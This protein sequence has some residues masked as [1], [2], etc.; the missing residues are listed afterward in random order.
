MIPEVKL[1]LTRK[2]HRISI[3]DI[4]SLTNSSLSLSDIKERISCCL[5]EIKRWMIDNV[6]MK[7]NEDKTQLLII[8]K[9]HVLQTL[10]G[11]DLSIKFG[12]SAIN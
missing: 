11:C 8:G 3:P 7:L 12:D 4:S 5:N 10:E 6:I 2:S 1:L 9:S